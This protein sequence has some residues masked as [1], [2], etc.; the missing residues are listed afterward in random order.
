MSESTFHLTGG[1]MLQSENNLFSKTVS[2][3]NLSLR[4]VSEHHFV[5]IIAG[6]VSVTKSKT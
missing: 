6:N 1:E 4:P 5:F 2:M 3:H